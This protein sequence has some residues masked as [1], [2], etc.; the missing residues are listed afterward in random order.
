[1]PRSWLVLA[2]ILVTFPVVACD[3][4]G[5][6]QSAD[7][8]EVQVDPELGTLVVSN[9]TTEPVAIHLDGQELYAV[10]PGRAATIRNLPNRAVD[11]YGI[12]RI[13]QKHYGLPGLTIEEGGE[14]EWTIRP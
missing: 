4:G 12:G 14:Y 5:E 1:M 13:S 7:E 9:R 10:Q 6:R 3:R 11:I 8:S 2:L